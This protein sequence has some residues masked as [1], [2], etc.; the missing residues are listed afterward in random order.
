MKI[1]F[2]L[3][4]L[5]LFNPFKIIAQE[6]VLNNVIISAKHSAIPVFK[7]LDENPILKI[8]VD[9]PSEKSFA[10]KNI[11]LK[12]NNIGIKNIEQLK[13]YDTDTFSSFS[14]KK[15]IATVSTI[16]AKTIVPININKNGGKHYFFI[17]IKLKENACIGGMIETNAIQLNDNAGNQLPI[18]DSSVAFTNP[19]GIV[20]RK[21]GDDHVNTYRIP[22]ITTTNKK[23][24]ISVYD[25]RYDNSRDLPANIDV[26]ISRSTNAGNTWQPMKVIIDMGLPAENSGVGDPSILFDPITKKIWVAALWSKGNHSIA[27]SRPGLSPDVT[28]QFM[29]VNSD[30]DGLTWSK[31]INITSQ[32]KNPAWKILFQGPGNGTTMQNGTLVFPAQYW[33]SAGLPQSSIIYSTDHGITWK[34]GNGAKPN[35]TESSVIETTPGTLMLNMRDNGG[36]FRSVAITKDMGET[37]TPHLESFHALPDPVCMGSLIKATMNI[38]GKSTEVLFFSNPNSSK[39]RDSITVKASLDLGKT[40]LPS[41]QLLIDERECYGYS[42]LTKIDDNTVGLI[43]EGVKDLFFVRIPINRIIK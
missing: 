19:I 24:L 15:L 2:F 36:K 17:S 26:G 37:W 11:E 7:H 29:L 1:I 23:T 30:D 40:W 33:D 38:K 32:V 43:Y 35:T 28:G 22:G 4:A 25:I 34:R 18:K 10:I 16:A 31:P 5:M 39:H 41:N 3:I 14:N 27:G 20:I 6:K 13:I 12:I 42:A 8:I 21:P 9:I